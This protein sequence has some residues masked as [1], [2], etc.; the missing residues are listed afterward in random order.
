MSGAKTRHTASHAKKEP[1]REKFALGLKQWNADHTAARAELGIKGP[2]KITKGS[3]LYQKI[4][5]I[6]KRRQEAEDKHMTRKGRKATEAS[7][8]RP[9]R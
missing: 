3:A 7:Q 4:Q 5:E 6:R 1:S 8:K 9:R 2:C